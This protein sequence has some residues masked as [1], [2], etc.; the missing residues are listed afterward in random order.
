MCKILQR[1]LRR[2]VAAT[3]VAQPVAPAAARSS[4]TA[5]ALEKVYLTVYLIPYGLPYTFFVAASGTGQSANINNNAGH[6]NKS[7][8]M[9][10]LFGIEEN[11]NK[12]SNSTDLMASTSR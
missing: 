2:H 7:K 4:A 10:D 11:Q 5:A 3:A 6:S 12:A 8:V 1:P 9:H